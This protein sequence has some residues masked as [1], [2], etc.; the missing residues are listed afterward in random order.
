MSW[1]ATSLVF[2]STLKGALTT[3][4]GKQTLTKAD[5]ARGTEA[6][7]TR[8]SDLNSYHNVDETK[9]WVLHSYAQGVLCRSRMFSKR[10]SVHSESGCA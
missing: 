4:G 3:S 5:R 7:L 6:R 10:G 9:A 8:R 2:I 1:G